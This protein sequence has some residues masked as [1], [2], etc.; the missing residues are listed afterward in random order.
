MA[1]SGSSIS[2]ADLRRLRG[3]MSQYQAVGKTLPPNLLREFMAGR[4]DASMAAGHRAAVLDLDERKFAATTKAEAARL[5]QNK[6]LSDRNYALQQQATN[7]ASDAAKTSGLL[8]LGTMGLMAEKEFGLVG[9]AFSYAKGLVTPDKPYLPST[10][11][12]LGDASTTGMGYG[13][14]TPSGYT[15]GVDSPS[16]GLSST[17]ATSPTSSYNLGGGSTAS[18][19]GAASTAALSTS[20]PSTATNLGGA[21]TTGM[22]YGSGAASGYTLGVNSPG[23]G[24]SSTPA[25]SSVSGFN[26]GGGSTASTVGTTP[27]ASTAPAGTAPAAG[28]NVLGAAGTYAGYYGLAKMGGKVLRDTFA[29]NTVGGQVGESLDR[30]FGVEQYWAEEANAPGW[31]QD[32]LDVSNPASGIEAYLSDQIGTWLCT[33]YDNYVGLTSGE[34]E[35]LT[36]FRKFCNSKHNAAFQ[37]YLDNGEELI[38]AIKDKVENITAFYDAFG[39]NVLKPVFEF[40]LND[41]PES[42]YDHY[43]VTTLAFMKKFTPDLAMGLEDAMR[44]DS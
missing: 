20:L 4:A 41:D 36:L 15:L 9:D 40:L 11:T 38:K 1:Y 33:E 2:P 19:A 12:N 5:A 25:T 14:S 29:D 16:L 28:G 42:A 7:N 17:P 35:L 32:V 24:L 13:S 34:G 21:A 18:T 30:P 23:V 44:E 39:H 31:V 3:L 37:Y 10:A 22:G 27:A 26:L 43:S 6:T 8:N